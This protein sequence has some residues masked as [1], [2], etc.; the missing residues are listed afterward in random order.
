M[1]HP[2][3][4]RSTL[5]MALANG[6]RSTTT[7]VWETLMA[8]KDGD[9]EKLKNLVNETPA[10]I[11]AQYNYTPPIHF[12]VRE[13]HVEMVK[14]ILDKGALDASYIT[15][16]F[17]DS[18]ITIAEDRGFVE[19]ANLL[20]EYLKDPSRQKYQGDNGEIFYG[21][22]TIEDEFQKAVNKD[23]TKRVKEIL[24][25]HPEFAKNETLS[26]GEGILMMPS[27]VGD[28]KLL[29]LLMNHGAKVP[30][31]SKWGRFYYFKHFKVAD[32]LIKNGMDPNHRTWHEVR[33]L[34]D[35]AQE[36][37]IDKAKLL[38]DYGAEI[39]PIDEE[40]HSTPLGLAARWGYKKMVEYLLKRGADP[41]K[42][43]KP[44]AKP[45]EWAR[46]KGHPIVEQMLRDAG[47]E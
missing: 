39:D 31:V 32:F 42:A 7:K 11:F 6:E 35:M 46:K 47:A 43:G 18:L 30:L 19:I 20:K 13:G 1:I 34:H 44:W 36:G 16:P 4:M 9:L 26:W 27:N 21:R 40:Y 8:S 14:Y 38:L 2:I 37:D 28:I 41:N 5:E 23:Q 17:K 12:A 15:Y 24:K 25:D 3:E 10:L 22:P 29:E 33:L 45:I